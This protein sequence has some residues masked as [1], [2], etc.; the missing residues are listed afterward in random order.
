MRKVLLLFVAFVLFSCSKD[1]ESQYLGHYSYKLSGNLTFEQVLPEPAEGSEPIEPKT[2]SISIIDEIGQL[3]LLQSP[4]EKSKRIVSMNATAGSVS[5]GEATI[6]DNKISIDF[7][8]KTLNIILFENLFQRSG[9]SIQV[10]KHFG[11]TG[12]GRQI[13]DTIVLSLNASGSMIFELKEYKIK[14]SKLECVAKL[15]Q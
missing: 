14:S 6:K 11:M 13:D 4:D 9:E 12:Q 15:N 2:F 1:A 8:D 7:A 3:S 10:K 5:I